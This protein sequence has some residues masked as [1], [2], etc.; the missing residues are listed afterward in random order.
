[1]TTRRGP[2][3]GRGAPK[4]AAAKRQPQ[5]HVTSRGRRGKRDPY[6]LLPPLRPEEGDALRTDIEARGV[7][8]PVEID[9]ASGAILDGHHRVAIADELG[10]RF[11][12]LKRRF[13]TEAE[14]I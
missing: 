1:M 12:S 11:P 8:V 3:A 6:Q 7:L 10:I 5:S 2:P 13:T 9:A 14:R 4:A